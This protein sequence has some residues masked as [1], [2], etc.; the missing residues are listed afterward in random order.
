V[1]GNG[2]T[3]SAAVSPFWALRRALVEQQAR[4][5]D[6]LAAV[7]QAEAALARLGAVFGMAPGGRWRRRRRSEMRPRVLSASP[8]GRRRH[9]RQGWRQ[10]RQREEAS[11]G[12]PPYRP[13]RPRPS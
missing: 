4:I 3:D 13:P 9:P 11:G 12:L 2:A 8:P 5:K 6:Q 1:R 10:A 7:E